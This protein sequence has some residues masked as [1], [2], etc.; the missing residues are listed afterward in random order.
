[1]LGTRQ[2]EE[3]EWVPESPEQIKRLERDIAGLLRRKRPTFPPQILEQ[4]IVSNAFSDAYATYLEVHA[5]PEARR[6]DD[7][8]GFIVGVGLEKGL[9]LMRSSVRRDKRFI[10]TPDTATLEDDNEAGARSASVKPSLEN[11]YLRHELAEME[12][13]SPASRA[14]RDD[15]RDAL[16]T[17]ISALTAK[18]RDAFLRC[19][20]ND[21]PK[22][23]AAA[24]I[25]I[26]Y[27]VLKRRI[28]KATGKVAWAI[29]LKSSDLMCD[30]YKSITASFLDPERP[31]RAEENK[32]YRHVRNCKQ[33]RDA[34]YDSP[35]VDALGPF[36]ATGLFTTAA[37]PSLSERISS[38][39]IIDTPV[40]IARSVWD[41]VSPGAAGGSEAAVG[42]T[43]AGATGG[44]LL[45]IGGGKVAALCA[46]T[47]ATVCVAGIATGVLPQTIKNDPK[48]DK[49]TAAITARQQ[50]PT[51]VDTRA[52]YEAQRVSIEQTI[53]SRQQARAER[54]QAR[55][56]RKAAA[57]KAAASAGTTT[58]SGSS[59]TTET[60]ASYSSPVSTSPTTQTETNESSAS[61]S[62]G[63][64][65][66]STAPPPSSGSTSTSSAQSSTNQSSADAS[67]GFGN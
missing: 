43:G 48:D 39:P 13:A 22:V 21:Q 57:E 12:K 52:V 37:A 46:G 60:Q 38:L 51:Y 44:T 24:E 19:V 66:G 42:A 56:A 62:F 6:I 14:L 64:G 47:A 29:S 34:V 2:Q 8:E 63:V 1:M 4:E 67:F 54:R 3:M 17:A 53:D 41:R 10:S 59:T 7:P 61:Q 36:F 65:G 33:C 23:E 31:S 58:D 27:N 25:G 9:K 16:L 11:A 30:S 26:A 15:R 49:A 35:M 5:D 40:E 50:E 55:A 18:E 28:D 45:A 32:I 20:V